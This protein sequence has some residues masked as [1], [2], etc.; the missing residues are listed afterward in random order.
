MDEAVQAFLDA[1]IAGDDARAEEFAMA[2][3]AVGDEAIPTLRDVLAGPDPRRRWWAPRAL[4]AIGTDAAKGLL[5]T[6]LEDADP[7]VRACAVVALSQLKP[8]E[9]VAPLIARLPDRSA[10][11]GRLAADAL[12]QF[13]KPAV[14]ALIDALREGET[15]ARAGAARALS[16]IQSEEAIPALYQALDDSSALVTYY[17]E[18][19]LEKMGVGIVLFRP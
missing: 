14:K 6:A 18:E 19:A 12:G 16:A 7:D 10:Y 1:V 3:P 4:A 17:A 8:E 15:T 11:V 2:L 9:A 13:G 5:I